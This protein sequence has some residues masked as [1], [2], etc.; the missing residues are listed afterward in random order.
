MANNKE[1]SIEIITQIITL[2]LKT[3]V[4]EILESR[5][6]DLFTSHRG[7]IK[8]VRHRH[9]G[10]SPVFTYADKVKYTIHNQKS[11]KTENMSVAN[12]ITE[13]PVI[14]QAEDNQTVKS[15]WFCKLKN[16]KDENVEEWTKRLR[17]AA[18][19]CEYQEQDRRIKEQFICGLDDECMQAKIISV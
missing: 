1:I 3:T 19:G 8:G 6:E 11:Y 14:I 16:Y 10:H 4:E 17:T 13:R 7:D 5:Q 12:D 18:E 9:N 2:A 15:L